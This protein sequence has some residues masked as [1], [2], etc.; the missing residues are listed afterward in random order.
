MKLYDAY[1]REVDTEQLRDEQAAPTMAGVRNIYS[2]MHPSVGLTPE[3]LAGIL[4][5][6]EFGDPFLYLELAE[7]MEEKDL[8]YLAVLGTRRPSFA[9]AIGV[10]APLK[11]PSWLGVSPIRALTL[12]GRRHIG[13]ELEKRL[14]PRFMTPRLRRGLMVYDGGRPSGAAPS[15]KE[16]GPSAA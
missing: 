3:R 15:N 14:L 11:V 7:E 12:G 16:D 13:A 2:V 6:A 4:R 8:H 9:R 5:Q 10:L 1:G